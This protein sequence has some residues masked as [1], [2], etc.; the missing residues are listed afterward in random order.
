[1]CRAAGIAE[2]LFQEI[3]PFAV[4]T[5]RV[6]VGT[7]AQVTAQVTA[8]VASL[9]RYPRSAKE[10]MAELGLKHW[11]TFQSNYLVPL[12]ETGVVERPIPDKPRSRMQRYK[13]T[14]A[15]LAVLKKGRTT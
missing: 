15:G 3:G 5:F 14:E 1:M 8:R 9:C 2:P 13:T 11:K 7:T 6:R 4:V 10:I 12:I